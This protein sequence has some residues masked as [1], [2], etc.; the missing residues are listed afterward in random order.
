MESSYNSVGR[1]LR[2]L[3]GPW[4]YGDTRWKRRKLRRSS[5]GIK[6]IERLDE[7]LEVNEKYIGWEEVFKWMTSQSRTSWRTAV[8]AIEQWDGPSDVD[9]GSWN[10]GTVWLDEEDQRHLERRYAR[11]GIATAYLI[12]E[13]SE[14]ALNG[15]QSI[16]NRIITLTEK[17]R[18]P[19][20]QQAAA[21]L[22]PVSGLD[23]GILSPKNTTYLKNDLLE[24]HNVLSAPEGESVKFLHALLVSAFLCT[25][26]G[27]PL[28]I[29][30]AGQLV[31]LQD[32]QDQRLRFEMLMYHAKYGPKGDDKFWVRM[33]NEILW[34]RGWGAEELSEGAD[35]QYGRGIL[36]KL[37]KEYIETEFL[38]ALLDN[39]RKFNSIYL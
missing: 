31:L 14:D 19:T 29:R 39:T 2:G 12:S 15:V 13:A 24:D 23:K 36:G 30:K 18:I 22:Y 34:L 32:E 37:P 38:K 5:F 26:A 25:R 27:S 9:L 21:L 20:L 8:Q 10:D 1:D 16:L 28:N 7:V 11:A 33:R 17:D 35:S 4:M 6:T 3:V